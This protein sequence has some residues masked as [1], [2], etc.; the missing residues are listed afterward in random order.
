MGPEE[1]TGGRNL[2]DIRPSFNVK[3]ETGKIGVEETG[4]R[5]EVR[6]TEP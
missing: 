4:F 2:S 5:G 3:E 1:G 6:N